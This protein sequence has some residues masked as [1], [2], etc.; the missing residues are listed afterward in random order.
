MGISYIYGAPAASVLTETNKPYALFWGTGNGAST[1]TTYA[2]LTGSVA[3][4]NGA[5]SFDDDKQ[6]LTIGKSGTYTLT[7]FGRGMYSSGGGT[8]GDLRFRLYQNGS[9]IAS[10]T[11]I[12]NNGSTGDI[13]ITASAGDEFYITSS[14]S[15]NNATR[16]SLGYFVR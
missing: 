12:T 11:G 3:V 2:T 8:A 10:Q 16:H 7:W 14:N 9:Q 5:M 1:H 15:T 13:T 6:V 4:T